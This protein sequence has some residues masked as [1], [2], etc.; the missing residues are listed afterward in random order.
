MLIKLFAISSLMLVFNITFA[1]TS[2]VCTSNL[3]TAEISTNNENQT[4]LNLKSKTAAISFPVNSQPM[5]TKNANGTVYQY[6]APNGNAVA[7]QFGNDNSCTIVFKS[8][9]IYIT[10]VG[11][12]STAPTEAH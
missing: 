3:V 12:A 6:I 1:A 8:G 10:N 2:Q 7:L 11:T 4:V 5:I 9:G